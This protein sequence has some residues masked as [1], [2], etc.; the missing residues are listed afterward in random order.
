MGGRLGRVTQRMGDYALWDSQTMW[1][2][3]IMNVQALQSDRNSEMWLNR[4]LRE[5]E[6]GPGD[7]I[8]VMD[9]A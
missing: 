7:S 2:C 5:L 4:A 9:L 6:P 1:T 3:T 8:S